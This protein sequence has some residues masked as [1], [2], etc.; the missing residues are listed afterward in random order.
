[1]AALARPF[2]E[3]FLRYV[4]GG[5]TYPYSCRVKTPVGFIAPTLHSYYDLLTLNEIF[6]R[7]DYSVDQKPRV[8]VDLGSNIGLSALYFLTRHAQTRCYLFEPD[9]ENIK[10]LRSNLSSF[11]GR[12]V[13]NPCAVADREEMVRFGRDVNSGRYGGIGLETGHYLEVPCRHINSV[14]EEVLQKEGRVDVLKIDTEGAELSTLKAI[15]PDLF[16]HID[17][18]F[19]EAEPDGPLFPDHFD[20]SFQGTVSHL[21]NRRARRP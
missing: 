3:V 14:L 9:P 20:Q 2:F 4:L 7:G 18:I 8:V 19:M 16:Q 13:L 21:S 17:D 15:R 12:Y 1:M 5:G 11:E 6:F 10:R